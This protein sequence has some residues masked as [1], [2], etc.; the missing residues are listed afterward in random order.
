MC[1]FLF[2]FFLLQKS[3]EEKN[4]PWARNEIHVSEVVRSLNIKSGRWSYR[5]L[6]CRRLMKRA[7]KYRYHSKKIAVWIR[8]MRL[9]LSRVVASTELCKLR[10]DVPMKQLCCSGSGHSGGEVASIEEWEGTAERQ[11]RREGERGTK[12]AICLINNAFR[13]H[14]GLEPTMTGRRRLINFSAQKGDGQG[15]KNQ[16]E[17]LKQWI[18]LYWGGSMLTAAEEPNAACNKPQRCRVMEE[19]VVGRHLEGSHCQTGEALMLPC[20][21]LALTSNPASTVTQVWKWALEE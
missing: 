8:E 10:T 9:V 6:L 12:D 1:F 2:L 21:S 7:L 11:Q 3:E 14:S 16:E 19:A 18:L 20:L 4:P 15:G 17:G 13:G 5:R